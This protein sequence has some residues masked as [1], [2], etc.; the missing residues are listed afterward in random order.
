MINYQFV[1]VIFF[2]YLALLSNVFPLVPLVILVRGVR[3]GDE[4]MYT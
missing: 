3:G 4:R 2:Y 1:C